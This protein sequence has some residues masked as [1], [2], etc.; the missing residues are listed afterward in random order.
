[1]HQGF[2]PDGAAGGGGGGRGMAIGGGGGFPIEIC[3]TVAHLNT[4]HPPL[5]KEKYTNNTSKNNNN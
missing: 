2:D 1:M 4:C 5:P 3:S